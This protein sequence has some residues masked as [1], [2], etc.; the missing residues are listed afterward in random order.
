[1]AC[2]QAGR[3]VFATLQSILMKLLSLALPLI[4]FVQAGTGIA[5][6]SQAAGNDS[7]EADRPSHPQRFNT[8]FISLK[9]GHAITPSY[10]TFGDGEQFGIEI[11]GE[12]FIQTRG[13]HTQRG[14]LFQAYFD[15]TLIK[16]KKHYRYTFS[17]KG[18]SLLGS[19]IA[20]LLVLSESIE[21]T[22]QK[23]EVSF[24]FLGQPGDA[25]PESNRDRLFPF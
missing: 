10:F 14:M 5:G 23:Q 22:D 20:G 11:P 8:R 17:I 21:E 15:A 9:Q 7:G 16:K 1:M 4:I 24:L 12:D 19:Y 3:D 6:L 13:S 2:S 25:A 18:V